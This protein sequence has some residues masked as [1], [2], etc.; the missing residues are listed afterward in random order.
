MPNTNHQKA[1]GKPQKV[2]VIGASG[3]ASVVADIIRCSGDEVVGFLDDRDPSEFTDINVFGKVDDAAKL[4]SVKLNVDGLNTDDIQFVIGIG[5]N[6]IRKRIVDRLSGLRYYTAI[7]PSAVIAVDATIDEGTVIMANA[8]INPGSS[9]GKHCI[10]NTAATVDHDNTIS[11]FVH[12]S[13]GVHLSGTVSIG[14]ETWLGTGAIVSNNVN[15]CGGCVIGA[16]AVIIKDIGQAGVYT[17]VPAKMDK[18]IIKMLH[19]G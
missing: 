19:G 10:I 15:I 4:S 13:P 12:L 3:H 9:V 5:K 17:G 6:E 7:H 18:N 8:V 16:G 14:E 11:D 2:I 1:N